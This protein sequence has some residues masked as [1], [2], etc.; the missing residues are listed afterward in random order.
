[1]KDLLSYNI[2]K[3]WE[4]S[5]RQHVSFF[6]ICVYLFI[7]YVRPHSLYPAIDIIPWAQTFIVLTAVTLVLDPE[8]KWV[9]NPINFW[10]M[11]FLCSVLISSVLAYAPAISYSRLS[12]FYTWL[13]IYFL[14]I[15]TVR[16]EERLFVFV[17][18]IILASAKMSFFGAREWAFRGFSFTSWGMKGPPG[19]FQNSGELAIQM[20]IMF[21]ITF[22]LFKAQKKHLSGIRYWF[23]A[24]CP[25]TA[26]MTIM[27][28]SSR[29]GQLAL[30]VQLLIVFK[31]KINIKR[32]IAAGIVIA[33]IY[34]FLPDEQK[35]R[36]RDIGQDGTSIQRLLYWEN[37]LE[38]LKEHP[39]A[40]VGYFNFPYYYGLYYSEDLVGMR[41]IRGA[42][43]PHNIF[44]Q[45]GADL[46]FLG[47]I[48]YFL[49]I[50]FAFLSNRKTRSLL[51]GRSADDCWLFALSRGLD[52]ALIGF[53]IAGQFVSV[54]YYPFLWMNLALTVCLLNVVKQ[55]VSRE[56]LKAT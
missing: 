16:N 22:Y 49:L 35:D 48:P 40:G 6:L 34:Q 46:G 8:K 17:L 28:A 41:A 43:L 52:L 39:V 29:G 19:F 23:L 32:I 36:F 37:G 5:R 7:E 1:M 47:L 15:W 9:S 54:V 44:V 18:I 3:T 24:L 4:T 21:G 31:E 50:L 55:K 10:L 42:E 12:D 51:S 20:L 27:A 53:I 38:M 13:I 45:V 33:L 25:L 11:F 14:I 26:A 56:N 30:A 2:G